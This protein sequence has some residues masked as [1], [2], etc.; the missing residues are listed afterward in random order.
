MQES[1]KKVLCMAMIP[2]ICFFLG[3]TAISADLNRPR[4]HEEMTGYLYNS[5]GH[6]IEITGYPINQAREIKVSGDSGVTNVT[7]TYLYTIDGSAFVRTESGS[8]PGSFLKLFLVNHYDQD[9]KLNVLT[10]VS[11]NWEVRDPYTTVTSASVVYASRGASSPNQRGEASV[12]NDFLVE[13]GF[14]EMLLADAGSAGSQ[15][16]LELLVDG[17]ETWT[18]VAGNQLECRAY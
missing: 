2:V 3:M 7:M 11:G 1:T 17:E 18:F 9:G 8:R 10:A 4:I 12:E 13:T 5:E 6:C 14:D 15:L 16:T